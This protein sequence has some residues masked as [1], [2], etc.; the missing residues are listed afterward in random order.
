M[1]CARFYKRSCV[2]EK[3][4]ACSGIVL[5]F[6]DCETDVHQ[7][8]VSRASASEGVNVQ[9][10]VCYPYEYHSHFPVIIHPN[11]FTQTIWTRGTQTHPTACSGLLG[12]DFSV[13]SFCF[14]VALV[15]VDAH[16]QDRSTRTASSPPRCWCTANSNTCSMRRA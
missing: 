10:S 14:V 3:T 7:L 4:G 5:C 6:F 1:S 12:N 8:R 2:G 13:R 9:T 11:T 16:H 15:F